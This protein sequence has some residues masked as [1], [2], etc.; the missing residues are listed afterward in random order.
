MW[1]RYGKQLRLL[2][3]LCCAGYLSSGSEKVLKVLDLYGRTP[4]NALLPEAALSS[5]NAKYIYEVAARGGIGF[6]PFGTDDNGKSRK[7][8]RSLEHLLQPFAQEYAMALGRWGASL[9]GALEGKI[10]TL[11]ERET[12]ML[13]R[14]STVDRQVHIIWK[15]RKEW[16]NKRM[17]S[18]CRKIS[19]G[20]IYWK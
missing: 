11:I 2:S 1:Y 13:N 8:I 19:S 5:E 6:S 20:V 3:H 10:K 14:K 7:K 9:N 16:N 15:Y 4:D 17:W 12:I 18:T